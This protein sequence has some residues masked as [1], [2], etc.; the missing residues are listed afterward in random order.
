MQYNNKEWLFSKYPLLEPCAWWNPFVGGLK[1]NFE[2]F[3][4]RYVLKE[5]ITASFVTETDNLGNTWK[6]IRSDVT[7]EKFDKYKG[8][9]Y[10]QYYLT[11]PGVP[12][13]CHFVKV[14]NN[15]GRYLDAEMFYFVNLAGKDTLPELTAEFNEGELKC[16]VYPGDVEDEFMYDNLIKISRNR[17]NPRPEKLYVY[18]DSKRDRGE[19][20]LG[21]D[22]DIAYIYTNMKNNAP[23]GESFT[24]MPMFCIMTE[25]DLTAED[26]G[27]L[28]RIEF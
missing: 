19:N 5:E 22:I 25:K 1:T 11:L 2:R 7:V 23:D 6:G 26:L 3:G 16:K 27:D 17:E 8:L 4:N 15:T 14:E 21:Y 20:E 28:R 10:S 18:K 24:T 9:R 13:V 12:V